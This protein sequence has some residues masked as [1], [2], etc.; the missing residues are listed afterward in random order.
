MVCTLHRVSQHVLQIAHSIVGNARINVSSS[1]FEGNPAFGNKR[2]S[3]RWAILSWDSAAVILS[4]VGLVSVSNS[5]A[6]CDGGAVA[7]L[8]TRQ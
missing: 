3:S 8:G 7:L 6:S 4:S 2:T 5:A 1:M